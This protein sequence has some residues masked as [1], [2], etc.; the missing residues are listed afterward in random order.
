MISADERARIEGGAL[1]RSICPHRRQWALLVIF[2]LAQEP[3]RAHG[4]KR[5]SDA[6]DVLAQLSSHGIK[7]SEPTVVSLLDEVANL[8][9]MASSSA[10]ITA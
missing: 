8:V 5:Y 3:L 7:L 2:A 6:S 4:G 9:P 1:K 10:K